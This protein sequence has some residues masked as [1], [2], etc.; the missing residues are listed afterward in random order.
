MRD[1]PIGRA[2]KD[3]LSFLDGRTFGTILADPPWQFQNRTGKIAP[4]HK[5]LSRYGTM[6]LAE[7]QSLPVTRAAEATAHLYLWVPNALLPEGLAVMGAW[8]F[9]YKGNIVWRKIRKD[10]GS[11][12]R[13]V[14]FYFRNVTELIL[15]GTGGRMREPCNPAAG[16]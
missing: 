12:G 11:D 5:R 8:G 16:R 2:A 10:G 14:G 7:I 3:F 9:Q 4:E 6:T 15:F 13:G 1:E